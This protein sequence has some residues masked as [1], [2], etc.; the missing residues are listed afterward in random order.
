[1]EQHGRYVIITKKEREEL[2]TKAREVYNYRNSGGINL[3]KRLPY[4]IPTY[5]DF[6][7]SGVP[8]VETLPYYFFITE[9]NE[10]GEYMFESN[11]EKLNKDRKRLEEHFSPFIIVVDSKSNFAE[12]MEYIKNQERLH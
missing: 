8:L 6:T 4:Y 7:M 12:A 1:M 2:R 9:K 3:K 5:R 11:N 10:N